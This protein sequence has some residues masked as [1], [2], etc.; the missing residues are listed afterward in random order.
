MCDSL[1][2]PVDVDLLRIQSENLLTGTDN[3]AESLVDFE[4][5]YIFQFQTGLCDGTGHGNGRRSWEVNGSS[6]GVRISYRKKGQRLRMRCG[7][8][9]HQAN[10]TMTRTDNLSNRLDTK[11]CG[12][13]CAHED[14]SASAIVESGRIGS[15][16]RSVLWLERRLQRG[17]LII[18]DIFVFL[19]LLDD[20]FHALLVFDGD[21]DDFGVEFSS[22]PSGGG[23]FVRQ[24]GMLILHLTGDAVFLGGVFGT[25]P[26]VDVVVGIPETVS[27]ER[28][29]RLDMAEGWIH[30][31]EVVPVEESSSSKHRVH[32]S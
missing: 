1:C 3:H 6:G 13:F 29:F 16:N 11:L 12:L 18:F 27:E 32:T 2:I 8:F 30:T 23:A 17:D 15:G 4:E 28:V 25:V 14:D 19:I 7:S 21:R 20:G 24:D 31:G 5:G 10:R 9:P 26:H 22:C